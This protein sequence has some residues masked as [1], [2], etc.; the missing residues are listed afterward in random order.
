MSLLENS[1]QL[2]V[3][4]VGQQIPNEKLK[5]SDRARSTLPIS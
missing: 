5:Y 1:R 2:S 4:R 3:I